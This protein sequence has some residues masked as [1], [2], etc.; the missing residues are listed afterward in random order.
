MK[1]V[2]LRSIQIL[3]T[4]NWHLIS[5]LFND[6]EMRISVNTISLLFNF[7]GKPLFD[8]FKET[9]YVGGVPKNIGLVIK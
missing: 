5:V 9:V 6:K 4:G 1:A 7:D 2:K 3:N 8:Q